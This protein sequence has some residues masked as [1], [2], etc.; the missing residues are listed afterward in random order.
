MKI[1]TTEIRIDGGRRSGTLGS[2]VAPAFV[3]PDSR[4]SISRARI[5]SVGMFMPGLLGE[6]NRG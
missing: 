2:R 6:E 3:E 5:G 1:P 4:S